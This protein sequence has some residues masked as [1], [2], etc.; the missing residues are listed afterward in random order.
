MCGCSSSFD[1][2]NEYD[3][4][5]SNRPKVMVYD[6]ANLDPDGFNNFTSN[7]P[8]EIVLNPNNLD[9]DGFNNFT[10]KPMSYNLDDNGF[11]NFGGKGKARRQAR[12]DAKKGI[13][14]NPDGTTKTIDAGTGDGTTDADKNSYG[15]ESWFSNN[16]IYLLGGLAVVGVGY[17]IYKKRQ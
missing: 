6:D 17:M 5:T 14:T 11:S 2:D 9:P 8:K 13:V 15:T 10:D 16:W 7:R 4:F 12:R 3:N 1:G